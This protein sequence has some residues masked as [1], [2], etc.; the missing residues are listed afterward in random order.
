MDWSKINRNPQAF[1]YKYDGSPIEYFEIV[2]TSRSP[3]SLPKYNVAEC[4][5]DFALV[6]NCSKICYW[7]LLGHIGSEAPGKRGCWRRLRLVVTFQPP[8]LLLQFARND[9]ILQSEL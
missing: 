2:I 9:A 8:Q 4:I 7:C 1:H 3:N 6:E 5:G